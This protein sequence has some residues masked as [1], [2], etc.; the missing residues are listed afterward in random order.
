MIS[1]LFLHSVNNIHPAVAAS[2]GDIP[3]SSRHSGG[4]PAQPQG[5]S[6]PTMPIENGL[7]PDS[8]QAYQ[9]SSHRSPAAAQPQPSPNVR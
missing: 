8:N 3:R 2:H 7:P 5:S 6:I 4:Y 1:L 9:H